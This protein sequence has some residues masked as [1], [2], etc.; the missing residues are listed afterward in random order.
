MKPFFMDLLKS[1]G[2]YLLI[3]VGGTFCFLTV[4]PVFGYVPYSDRPGPGWYGKF[5][6]LSWTQFWHGAVDMFDWALLL[7]PYAVVAGL[8]LFT[9]ARLLERFRTPR[10]AVAIVC[11][12]V[13]WIGSG[14]VVMAIGW[15]IAI[16]GVAVD[17]AAALG[18][19]YGGFLL[20]RRRARTKAAPP[21]TT[22]TDGAE[23]A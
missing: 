9:V 1:I 15:Y 13:G 17:L 19:V 8:I 3:V 12:V 4:A 21:T 23:T 10:V 14:Y 18:L 11:A 6:A 7:V 16:G 2:V 20:P 22:S 5:P